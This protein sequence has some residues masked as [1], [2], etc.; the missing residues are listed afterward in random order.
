MCTKS[1]AGIGSRQTPPDVLQIMT[2]FAKVAA[3]EGWVLRS[4]AAPGADAAFERGADAGDGSKEIF[5]PWKN[6]QG[7]SSSLFTST[8]AALNIATTLHPMWSSLRPAVKTLITRNVHQVLGRT[9]DDPCKFV[10]CW[11]PDGCESR[12]EYSIRTG[13][14]G[15]AIC[16]ASDRSIPVFNL[17]NPGRLYDALD[18]VTT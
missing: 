10:V 6:F 7:S 8:Q 9:V 3:G 14:T 15:T 13:G 16:L 18:F 4:G 11:T 12:A 1:Y 2:D 5:I 17:R